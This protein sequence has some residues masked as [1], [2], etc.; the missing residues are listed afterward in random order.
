MAKSE[1]KKTDLKAMASSEMEALVEQHNELVKTIQD[2]QGRL[3]EVKSMLI[4]KQG[5]LKGLEACEEECDK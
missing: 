2:A 4:E 5:Y 1:E 3:A